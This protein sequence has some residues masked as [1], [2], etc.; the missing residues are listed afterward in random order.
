VLDCTSGILLASSVAMNARRIRPI[1]L[2]AALTAAATAIAVASQPVELRVR[3]HYFAE[4]ATVHINVTV[5]PDAENRV[6]RVEADGERLF[7]SAEVL[8]EGDTDRRFHTIEFRNLPAGR[9]TLRAEV[10]SSSS[11][12]RGVATEQLLVTGGS[13]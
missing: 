4:P 3:G 13:H 8:L 1:A 5:E 10:L 9:Y 12:V 6:L 7:R 2:T 11:R